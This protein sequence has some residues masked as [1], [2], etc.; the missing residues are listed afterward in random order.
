MP[1]PG[2]LG[3]GFCSAGSYKYASGLGVHII[4]G[5]TDSTG[6]NLVFTFSSN[7]LAPA[8]ASDLG[9]ANLNPNGYGNEMDSLS[10]FKAVI[11]TNP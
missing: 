11:T 2:G 10:L 4:N 3:G 5:F 6:K 8:S 7:G 1:A 9:G